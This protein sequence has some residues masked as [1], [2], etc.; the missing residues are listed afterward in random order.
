MYEGKYDLNVLQPLKIWKHIRYKFGWTPLRGCV[1]VPIPITLARWLSLDAPALTTCTC[2][3]LDLLKQTVFQ[4]TVQFSS[5]KVQHQVKI[6]ERRMP[7]CSWHPPRS[8]SPLLKTMRSTIMSWWTIFKG[9]DLD[10][11]HIWHMHGTWL[12][13]LPALP[14]CNFHCFLRN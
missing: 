3:S 8:A 6:A 4:Q 10:C 13:S 14:S 9:K 5:L 1:L 7:T 11:K 12:S 2:L